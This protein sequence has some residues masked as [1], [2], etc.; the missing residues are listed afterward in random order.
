MRE[1]YVCHVCRDLLIIGSD[2]RRI[3]SGSD[4]NIVHFNKYR[5]LQ[6]KKKKTGRKPEKV[7][8]N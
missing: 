6:I 5:V 4:L 2:E 7:A 3:L 1:N 8:N